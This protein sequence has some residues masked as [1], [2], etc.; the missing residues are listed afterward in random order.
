MSLSDQNI[1]TIVARFKHGYTKVE[2]LLKI[3]GAGS[4][5]IPDG[6]MPNNATNWPFKS[7][8]SIEIHAASVDLDDFPRL[9]E[10][11]LH[12]S[13]KP[14]LEEIVLVGCSLRGQELPQAAE[15]TAAI[16]ITIREV[17]YGRY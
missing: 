7:L 15:R 17:R 5:D 2:S 6:T 11:Y 1:R 14:L 16:G 8:E 4:P 9:V 13:S 3:I 12:K 10:G